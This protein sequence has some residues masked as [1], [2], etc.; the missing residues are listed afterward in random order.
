M[1][2][3]GNVVDGV[4]DGDC[5]STM[6]HEAAMGGQEAM[7][8]RLLE[9][10]A[11]VST[12]DGNGCT[13][14][15][16]A[17]RGGHEAVV[18][19]LLEKGAGAVAETENG[20]TLL[21]EAARNGHEVV[22][23]LLL[24]KGA[25]INSRDKAGWTP[26]HTAIANG[27][28]K[29]VQLLLEEGANVDEMGSISRWTAL[30][31][32]TASGHEAMVQLLLKKGANIDV[33]GGRYEWTALH[34]AAIYGREAVLSILLE[35]GA[36]VLAKDRFGYSILRCAMVARQQAAVQIL[37]DAVPCPIGLAG[38]FGIGL[39]NTEK[40]D[41]ERRCAAMDVRLH[42]LCDLC[43]KINFTPH[44]KEQCASV[45]CR[46]HIITSSENNRPFPERSLE[47]HSLEY[48]HHTSIDKL[49]ASAE[50]GCHLCS[51][52]AFGLR[53]S[54]ERLYIGGSEKP[55]FDMDASGSGLARD[56]GVT[57][58]YHRWGRWAQEEELE[59]FYS[60]F[61]IVLPIANIPPKR[62]Y[63]EGFR[64]VGWDV[65]GVERVDK[66]LSEMAGYKVRFYARCV[67]PIHPSWGYREYGEVGEGPVG[68]YPRIQSYLPGQLISVYMTR[69]KLWLAAFVYGTAAEP[70]INR[71]EHATYG[72]VDGTDY[73]KLSQPPHPCSKPG[74]LGDCGK[75]VWEPPLLCMA[76]GGQTAYL[77]ADPSSEETFSLIGS[78][79]SSCVDGHAACHPSGSVCLPHRVIDVGAP[80]AKGVYPEPSLSVGA[81]RPGQYATLSYRWGDSLTLAA[82]LSTLESMKEGIAL[83]SM[84]QTFQDAIEVTRRLGI[85]YLWIDALCI[86]QDS[87]QDWQKQSAVMGQIYMD[88]WLNI[89]VGGALDPQS[90]FLKERNILEIRSCRHPTL[91]GSS[92]GPNG[93][94][95]STAKVICPTVPR[96]DQV[97]SQDILNSR[98]WVL[99]ERALSKRTLHFDLHEIYWE[100]LSHSATEREPEIFRPGSRSIFSMQSR[101]RKDSLDA[102]RNGVQ[103]L[104]N[105]NAEDLLGFLGPEAISAPCHDEEPLR[106]LLRNLSK[107]PKERKVLHFDCPHYHPQP[108][109][110][111]SD[112]TVGQFTAAHSLW[113][114]LVTEYTLRLLTRPSDRLPAVSGLARIFQNLF[115]TRSK[116]VAG[117]W[118]GDALNGLTWHRRTPI[119]EDAGKGQIADSRPPNLCSSAPSFSWASVDCAVHFS[120]PR[121]NMLVGDESYSAEILSIDS[122]PLGHN[123]LGE[124]SGGLLRL[125]AW[126]IP[127]HRILDILEGRSERPRKSDFDRDGEAELSDKR[128]LCISLR[129]ISG[130]YLGETPSVVKQC[131]LLLP[132]DL[133]GETYRRVGYWEQTIIRTLP[134][135]GIDLTDMV[136]DFDRLQK[137][138]ESITPSYEGWEMM[139][140]TI[141]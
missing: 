12:R 36:D 94:A 44:R 9:T 115:G 79:L 43:S 26:L 21:H 19:L 11:D 50:N 128:I 116:S 48:R 141:V 108:V 33:K 84:P 1:C 37:L 124:V 81:N 74:C 121:R 104:C 111:P 68:R 65:S 112:V 18:Q 126:A 17:A 38:M 127:L 131:L 35:K 13:A 30:Q 86:M 55:S 42:Q 92:T 80:G 47:D 58:V 88:A 110:V 46:Y 29:V 135:L 10:G 73:V 76:G 28:G 83:C 136:D 101:E 62:C 53:Y 67:K 56:S 60:G 27:Q 93:V 119:T 22:I 3:P 41:M 49:C 8:R 69:G 32:A 137:W 95:A 64:E 118:S 90:G 89:S 140:V 75:G 57:L 77:A 91:L 132:T 87:S 113:Y 70:P 40:L 82:T 100:C 107:S 7:V 71:P 120:A 23:Q 15:R 133:G 5:G 106:W 20:S 66:T 39:T 59:L 45:G 31:G 14:L 78:W 139:E 114:L 97:L 52:L 103:Y 25:D 61:I 34:L 134:T 123:P 96:H 105:Q 51:L 99:Q 109:Y 16:M 4:A 138:V 72:W 24:G 125:R 129:N 6:L 63:E 2:Q 122:T 85:R 54:S 130:G 98:G 102:I 117:I